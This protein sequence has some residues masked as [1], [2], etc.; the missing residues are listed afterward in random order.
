MSNLADRTRGLFAK[1]R[2]ERLDGKEKGP[3]FVLAPDTDPFARD[4]IE[5]YAMACDATHQ[6]LADD[7]L[8]WRDRIDA[9]AKQREEIADL[10]RALENERD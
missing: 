6:Q 7:L 5:A 4:A 1:Y 2:V 9:A 8:A 3:Y 10:S